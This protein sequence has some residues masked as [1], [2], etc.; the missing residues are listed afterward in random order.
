MRYF[1]GMLVIALVIVPATSRA[2]WIVETF[3]KQTREERTFYPLGSIFEIRQSEQFGWRCFVMDYDESAKI[4]TCSQVG[5]S[6][7][8]SFMVLKTACF[9]RAT[10]TLSSKAPQW[11][12]NV[13]LLWDRFR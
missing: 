1:T 7:L 9:S 6:S 12:L 13:T 8:F 10:V 4:L 5:N 11:D 3:D 2:S